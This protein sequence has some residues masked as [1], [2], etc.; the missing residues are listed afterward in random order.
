MATAS[1][2]FCR[3]CTNPAVESIEAHL[4]QIICDRCGE[5]SLS[6]SCAAILGDPH[7]DSSL[8]NTEDKKASVGYWLRQAQRE[9]GNPILRCEVVETLATS[10]WFPSLHDQRQNIIRLLGERAGAPGERVNLHNFSDQFILGCRKMS[11]VNALIAHLETEGSVEII[12]SSGFGGDVQQFE[13][14]LTF[15]GWLEFEDI[16]SGKSWVI[17]LFSPCPL[18]NR[19]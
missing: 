3:I 18:A 10:P 6:D 15:N 11:A 19:I 4:I 5:F 16:D 14:A 9:G 7:L 8:L 1:K 2:H 12:R 17:P 13:L